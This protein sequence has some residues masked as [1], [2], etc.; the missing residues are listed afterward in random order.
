MLLGE[1]GGERERERALP[2]TTQILGLGFGLGLG[3]SFVIIFFF[4]S[5]GGNLGSMI[6]VVVFLFPFV[7][8]SNNS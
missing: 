4:F 6:A 8:D 2:I 1:D 5:C 3:F 7:P